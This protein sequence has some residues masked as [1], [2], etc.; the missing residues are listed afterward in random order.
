MIPTGF[1]AKFEHKV[2]SDNLATAG[3]NNDILY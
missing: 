1:G 3:Y 2:E